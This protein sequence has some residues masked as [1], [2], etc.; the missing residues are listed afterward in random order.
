MAPTQIS[1][2][3]GFTIKNAELL[4]LLVA[5]MAADPE[6][7]GGF[8]A[9]DSDERDTVE[10]ATDTVTRGEKPAE[11]L[12]ALIA[13]E[14][15]WIHD[16][17]YYEFHELPHFFGLGPKDMGGLEKARA[18]FPELPDGVR[19]F[20][21]PMSGAGTWYLGI[22]ISYIEVPPRGRR[23]KVKCPHPVQYS[24]TLRRLQAQYRYALKEAHP[25][26]FEITNDSSCRSA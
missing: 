16:G 20:H 24:V 8:K 12:L 26:L 21:N 14:N 15:E 7:V 3:Y 10:A 5:Q 19:M 22:E 4:K 13:K 17:K 2:V 23:K 6:F 25:D 11:E 9:Y 18:L 1:W